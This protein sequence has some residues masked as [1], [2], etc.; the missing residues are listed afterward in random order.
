MGR[1]GKKAAPPPYK[2]RGSLPRNPKA[3]ISRDASRFRRSG[4]PSPAGTFVPA[5]DGAPEAIRPVP[6]HASRGIRQCRNSGTTE[7]H[8]PNGQ[9]AAVG[10]RVCAWTA[11]IRPTRRQAAPISKQKAMSPHQADTRPPNCGLTVFPRCRI[12]AVVRNAVPFKDLHI[13]SQIGTAPNK[14]GRRSERVRTPVCFAAR[15]TSTAAGSCPPRVVFDSAQAAYVFLPLA[16]QNI[17]S[18]SIRLKSTSDSIADKASL[19]YISST[20]ENRRPARR[21]GRAA[22]R[23]R[24]HASPSIRPRAIAVTPV[25]ATSSTPYFFILE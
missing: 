21:S 8:S 18:K 23:L 13:C 16:Y 25:R 12:D 15:R 9:P 6:K 14:K 10:K 3:D 2:K 22:G 4:A 24:A 7:R 1:K 19:L 20:E 11:G 17:V 5:G